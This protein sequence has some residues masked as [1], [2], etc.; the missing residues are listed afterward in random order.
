[1]CTNPYSKSE[2]F[3][4]EATNNRDSVAKLLE[5]AIDVL[6]GLRRAMNPIH[7]LRPL[8]IAEAAKALR[9]RREE[10]D[11]LIQRGILPV[12]RRHGRRYI[13]P[14]DINRRLR[15]EAEFEEKRKKSS[16]RRLSIFETNEGI[17]IDPALKEFFE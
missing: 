5:E 15:E 10:V 17:N 11:S 9:C 3:S 2:V 14:A 6:Q 13:L 8:S 1:M 7:Q 4:K 16:T 12:I